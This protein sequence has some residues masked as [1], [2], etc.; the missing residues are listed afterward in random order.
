M[1][2]TQIALAA[3]VLFGLGVTSANA[4]SAAGAARIEELLS[5]G[6]YREAYDAAA[7][8]GQ[9]DPETLETTARAL[10][11]L[12]M[13][14]D[15]SFLR[16][17]SLRAA[18][19]L[20]DPELVAAARPLVDANDRYV[21]SLSLEFLAATDLAGNRDAFVRA[22]DSPYRTVR[23]R[24]IRALEK[25]QDP[26]LVTRLGT[27]LTGDPDAELR[28]MAA[29][30]LGRTGAKPAIPLLSL[31]LDDPSAVVQEESVRAL[32]VL[33][34]QRVVGT[35]KKRLAE[36]P[37]Q[38]RTKAVRLAALVPDAS[39]IPSLGPLL[40]DGDPEVRAFTASAILSIRH[41]T[42]GEAQ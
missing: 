5:Q 21:Q 35:L 26:A 8:E 12:G 19:D 37:P 18:R 42:S 33:G 1:I 14:S 6:H 39:L 36:A 32:V 3:L 15:D 34:D 10:L 22:L 30:A 4:E 38:E 40:G 31:A 24:A 17:F 13:G 16:W 7:P 28:A 25:L 29:R 20:S 41:R 2:P 27:V 11:R 9:A 23:I